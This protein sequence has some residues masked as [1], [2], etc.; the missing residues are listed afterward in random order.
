M[1]LPRRAL[2]TG[3]HR[4]LVLAF[5]VG[6]T[7]TGI[8]YSIL[9]PGKVPE[10]KG[11]TS[12][13]SQEGSIDATKIPSIMY[14]GKS[15]KLRVAGFE[16][17]HEDIDKKA[18]DR[19][20]EKVEWFKI[21]FRARNEARN[22]GK[23]VPP[24]PFRKSIIDVFADFLRYVF[25]CATSYIRNTYHHGAA[26]WDSLKHDIHFII[27][28]PNSWEDRE[29]ELM[30]KAVVMG[31]ASL[32]FAINNDL[33]SNA[34]A[35]G[36][37]LAI[38]DA[39][40][41]T[42]DI[43]FYAKKYLTTPMQQDHDDTPSHPPLQGAE[44][45]PQPRGGLMERMQ[46][47]VKQVFH[48]HADTL[49]VDFGHPDD[50]ISEDVSTT[51]VLEEVLTSQCHFYGSIFVSLYA[52][53]FLEKYLAESEFLDDIEHIVRQFDM[54]TK[55]R[56]RSETEPQYI[57]FGSTRD[58]DPKHNIRF[59][60]LKLEGTD[61]A[62]FF[63]PSVDAIVN[64]VLDGQN[65][66]PT[67]ISYVI[68]VG[69]FAENDWLSNEVKSTL[70]P[71]GIEVFRPKQHLNK[72]VSDGA[73]SFYLDHYVRVRVAKVTYGYFHDIPFDS[74]LP[75]HRQREEHTFMSMGGERRIGN[76]FDIILP[77][78]FRSAVRTAF[79]IPSWT[80]KLQITT[81]SL[82]ICHGRSVVIEET[83]F[84]F[85]WKALDEVIVCVLPV[86]EDVK[87]GVE[88]V[89]V[90]N[91]DHSAVARPP[92]QT[93]IQGQVQVIPAVVDA[94]VPSGVSVVNAPR[95]EQEESVES[96]LPT[97]PVVPAISAAAVPAKGRG[98]SKKVA[99]E[100][101]PEVEEDVKVKKE[102]IPATRKGAKDG[103]STSTTKKRGPAAKKTPVKDDNSALAS[104]VEEELP[105][106][107]SSR[108]TTAQPHNEADTT[109]GNR[110]TTASP[111]H[112]V[113]AT[114]TPTTSG[115][116]AET[117]FDEDGRV[118]LTIVGPD[119]GVIRFRARPKHTV[120]KITVA[121]C[122]SYDLE[123]ES[124]QLDLVRLD[125]NDQP[126]P[127]IY[128]CQPDE[129]IG[130]LGID[131]RTQLILRVPEQDDMFEDDPTE[132]D[133]EEE[134]VTRNV[135]ANSQDDEDDD[136]IERTRRFFNRQK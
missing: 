132:E 111:E 70:A 66:S 1:A 41:G 11:V 57:H 60:Q 14:Y 8:S 95:E 119:G 81:S 26:L 82:D 2:Y 128:N 135:K 130:R 103:P 20:W 56:F 97:P 48:R 91:V 78:A 113:A 104:P 55:I 125:E 13:P 120:K 102:K 39:G 53:I 9:E 6:T 32:H 5:D 73:I 7:Y 85:L 44:T 30:R 51:Q 17:M 93:Q 71:A 4:K 15:G 35:N 52:R 49:D 88:P 21:H 115:P 3:S 127:P 74:S 62:G 59:G 89:L 65:I 92:P 40:G 23:K 27:S 98:R 84:P 136:A 33:P 126:C 34:L 16:A 99:V 75:D 107:P 80:T 83:A 96:R 117:E 63:R 61:V 29:H 105:E 94:V 116:N 43:S 122:K 12:F 134:E 106:Q 123:W 108:S 118:E 67:P 131:E 77:K 68:L 112:D 87:P 101:K 37:G 10:I 90:G 110:A 133:A 100:E 129:L 47:K 31:E 25:Q 58:N 124:A 121:A 18:L 54:T 38:V 24:P 64:A 50:G 109:I 19:D 46:N 86:E 42:I 28:H 36:N 45:A 79:S 76:V 114:P 69:G 72:A 22:I